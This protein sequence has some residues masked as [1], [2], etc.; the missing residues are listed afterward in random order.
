MNFFIAI[1]R[2]HIVILYQSM[3]ESRDYDRAI[4]HFESIRPISSSIPS[5]TLLSAM[6]QR[7][8][9]EYVKALLAT[10][11]MHRVRYLS[12]LFNH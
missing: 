5:S 4:S 12:L 11:Q 9:V 6:D 10:H 8:V 1:L 3:N 2:F 7:L